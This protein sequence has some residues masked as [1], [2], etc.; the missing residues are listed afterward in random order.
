MYLKEVQRMNKQLKE[1]E[2]ERKKLDQLIESEGMASEAT[3]KQS[4]VVGSLLDTIQTF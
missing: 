2:R 4:K 1:L 3:I